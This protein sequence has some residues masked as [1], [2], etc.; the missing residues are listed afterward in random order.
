MTH[1]A[2]KEARRR[3]R[4]PVPTSAPGFCKREVRECYRIA[5]SRSADA[6]E[7]WQQARHRHPEV[8]PASIPRGVPVFWLGGSDGHGHVSISTGEGGHWTTDLIRP[9]WFDRTGIAR[10]S[11]V[12]TNLRLVG[13]TEDLDGERVW[14]DGKPVAPRVFSLDASELDAV[15]HDIV[16]EVDDREEWF[17]RLYEYPATNRDD[18]MYAA[19]REFAARGDRHE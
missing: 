9:G 3:S 10:V 12:W 2:I 4:S 15:T 16:H 18:A 11:R 8:D 5:V 17:A 6:A 19:A 13:W 14:K 7:A 1:V